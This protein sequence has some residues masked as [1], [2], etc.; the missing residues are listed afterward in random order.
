MITQTPT[1]FSTRRRPRH[2]GSSPRV[3]FRSLMPSISAER[4]GGDR[5]GRPQVDVFPA[6]WWRRDRPGHDRPLSGAGGR[7]KLVEGVLHPLD[8]LLHL[9]GAVLDHDDVV[10]VEAAHDDVGRLD[11]AAQ[12]V[13]VVARP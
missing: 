3:N 9:G 1:N 5:S 11:Q 2:S 6:T 7:L 12:R 4:Y 13:L 8:R 10:L